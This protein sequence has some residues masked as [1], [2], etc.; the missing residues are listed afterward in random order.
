MTQLLPAGMNNAMRLR[1]FLRSLLLQS[2]WNFERMQ[3]LGIAYSL[4][5]WLQRVYAGR[6]GELQ[7]ALGRH[8]EFFNTQPYM[9]SLVIGMVCALEEQAAALPQAERTAK[10]NRLKAM[11]AGVAAALAGIGD[12]FFWGALRPFCAAL[13][14]AVTLAAWPS[15]GAVL[16]GVLVYLAAFNIF[17]LSLRWTGLRLGYDWNENIAVRLKAMPAQEALRRLR[18]FGGVLA[19]AACAFASRLAASNSRSILMGALAVFL[20]LKIRNFGS[21]ELYGG[22]CAAGAIGA[23]AGWI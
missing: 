17:S 16:S 6:P 23:A 20:A 1:I 10:W 7:A 12:A 18:L 22:A 2:C 5:P 4:E 3:S 11:K 13:A 21:L 14:L 19:L 15:R 9:A 8:Q